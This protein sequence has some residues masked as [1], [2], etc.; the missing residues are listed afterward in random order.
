MPS[1]STLSQVPADM[2][3]GL[4]AGAQRDGG[5]GGVLTFILDFPG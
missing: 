5:M 1:I 3:N 2:N 4:S